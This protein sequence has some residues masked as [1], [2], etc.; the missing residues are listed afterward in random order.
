M[1]FDAISLIYTQ[2]FGMGQVL[3]LIAPAD[4]IIERYNPKKVWDSDERWMANNLLRVV[5]GA[6]TSHYDEVWDAYSDL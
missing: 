3:D 5:M 1:D 4:Y 2:K 6:T